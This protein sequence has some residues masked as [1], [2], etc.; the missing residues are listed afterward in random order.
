M[1]KRTCTRC[2]Y[3]DY[4]P[5][6][7]FDANGVCSY[8][9]MHDALEREYPTGAEGERRLQE[10]VARMKEAGRGRRYDCVVGVSGGCDSSFLLH[11]MKQYGLRPLAAHFDNTWNSSVATQNIRHITMALDVDLHT[12]VVDN[13][14]YDD[15]Y[16]S[17]LRAGVLELDA[18]TDIG[19]AA[20]QYMAAEKHGVKYIVEGHS[21]RTEGISPLGWAY[22]D[23]K[24]IENV[25]KQFGTLP[26]H[27]FPNLWLHKQLKWMLFGRYK[28]VRPLYYMD[29]RKEEAKAFMARELGW[30]WYGGHHL[31]NRISAF[32]HLYLIPVRFGYDLRLLGYSA[33]IRSGQMTRREG[34]QAM[35]D[36]PYFKPDTM[37]L[38]E[39]VKKRLGLS[40]AE[41]DALMTSPI[42][43]YRD[44][45]TYKQTFE[46]M[47]PFF[48]LMYKLELVPK[49][50]YM[51]FTVKDEPP[52]RRPELVTPA[53]YR[54]SR[55]Q[56]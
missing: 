52:A 28:R 32:C 18:P 4:V 42:K 22:V 11:R 29:Y 35:Q 15:L 48:W 13:R 10:L 47:R 26:L 23:G 49:S 55:V 40:D 46:R 50:F 6:I 25:Q 1:S 16:R 41:F 19:L 31:E 34:L 3:D 37:A 51:K 9:H 27:T 56:A 12:V 38:V 33:L 14:E 7:T 21:F 39:L 8:C 36:R 5:K 30:Q 45:S 24:Y 2:L 44:Y 20:V 54:A 17:F 43:T 53:E